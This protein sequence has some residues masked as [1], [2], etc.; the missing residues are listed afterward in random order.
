MAYY[1]LH[2]HSI[3][4][5]PVQIQLFTNHTSWTSARDIQAMTQNSTGKPIGSYFKPG[6][7]KA[8]EIYPPEFIVKTVRQSNPF[9]G[10]YNNITVTLAA[11]VDLTYPAS[12]TIQ[13]FKIAHELES[14]VKTQPVNE[15]HNLA[16]LGPIALYNAETLVGDCPFSAGDPFT[17]LHGPGYLK[18]LTDAE[19]AGFG[20]FNDKHGRIVLNLGQGQ[21]IKAGHY[22]SF[23]F[24]F[25]NPYCDH[26]PVEP[27][28]ESKSQCLS[29]YVLTCVFPRH[30]CR[31]VRIRLRDMSV[32]FIC[33]TNTIKLHG[34]PNTN[35]GNV[36]HTLY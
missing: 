27:C 4:Q 20:Y 3:L 11:N 10:M 7:A 19:V 26:E 2:I 31:H 21:E 15:A 18:A 29:M 17:C 1:I 22:F 24:Q 35:N 13:G 28:G 32:V 16:P 34:I 33:T 9:P 36:V 23:R 30:M 6:D 8:L 25:R 12:I 14:E 5:P